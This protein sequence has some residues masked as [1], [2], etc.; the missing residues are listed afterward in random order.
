MQQTVVFA[1]K[2]QIEVPEFLTTFFKISAVA[3]ELAS[4]RDAA[5]RLKEYRVALK[6][7]QLFVSSHESVTRLIASYLTLVLEAYRSSV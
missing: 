7:C 4:R 2:V 6:V 3:K 5:S 1:P